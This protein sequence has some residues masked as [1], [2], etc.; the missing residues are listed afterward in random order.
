MTSLKEKGGNVMK[1]KNYKKIVLPT[2]MAA[3]LVSIP[4]TSNAYTQYTTSYNTGKTTYSNSVTIRFTNGKYTVVS[5]SEDTSTGSKYQYV[6]RRGNYTRPVETNKPEVEVPSTPVEKP[7]ENVD[8]KPTPQPAPQPKPTPNENTNTGSTSN[9]KH[10]LSAAEIQMV[11]LVNKER[12]AAGLKPL[13]I[14]VDLAYVARVKSQDMNDNKYFSHNSPTYGS[15]FEMMTKFGI[16]YRGAA[17]NIAK[18][19]SLQG[20][21]TSLMNSSGHRANIMN[22]NYTHIGIGIVNGYYTQMFI[23]K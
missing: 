14:D 17:E 21:H 22:P 8:P 12:Q 4:V 18:N 6:V 20:A 16:K 15:P 7:E 10:S 9:G 13:Q 19:S 2:V 11:E 3:L 23:S 5:P 1:F